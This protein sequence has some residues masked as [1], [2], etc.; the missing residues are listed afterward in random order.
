MKNS[1]LFLSIFFLSYSS[2]ASSGDFERA[3][4]AGKVAAQ[5]FEKKLI[6]E[7]NKAKLDKENLALA[8]YVYDYK[9]YSIG[10]AQSSD[11]YIVIF[12]LKRDKHEGPILGGGARYEID[13]NSLKI[14]NVELYE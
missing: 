11:S 5:N 2:A 7:K 1:S 13:I 9:N 3:F 14:N 8:N 10:L 4:E 6:E 12:S